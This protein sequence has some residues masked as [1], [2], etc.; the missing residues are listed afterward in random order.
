MA[1]AGPSLTPQQDG[2]RDAQRIFEAYGRFVASPQPETESQRFQARIRRLNTRVNLLNERTYEAVETCRPY[3][4]ARG[5]PPP[6]HQTHEKIPAMLLAFTAA[7]SREP[8]ALKALYDQWEEHFDHYRNWC[9]F[10]EILFDALVSSDDEALEEARAYGVKTGQRKE[11]MA[12]ASVDE[13]V[14]L[15]GELHTWKEVKG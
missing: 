15:Y 9:I 12:I 1:G 13:Y 7:A 11:Y 14:K 5:A 8:G 3:F 6:P 10:H 2:T 4:E